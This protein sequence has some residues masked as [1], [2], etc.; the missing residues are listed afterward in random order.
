M[1][2]IDGL[3]TYILSDDEMRET[4]YPDH[5]EC[6]IEYQEAASAF[7]EL[8]DKL[9]IAANLLSQLA[10]TDDNN[11]TSDQMNEVQEFINEH[12]KD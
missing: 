1:S 7:Y 11:R 9:T 8:E 3:A 5:N 4:V 2:V 10:D 12:T 6:Y